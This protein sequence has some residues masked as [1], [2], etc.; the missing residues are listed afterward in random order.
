MDIELVI[1]ALLSFFLFLVLLALLFR[2]TREEA[3]ITWLIRTFFTVGVLVVVFFI[4]KWGVTEI[5]FWASLY[6]LLTTLFVFGIFSIM[7]ASLT[8]RIFTE[9]ADTREG[10]TIPELMKKYNRNLIITRRIERLV[11]SKELV[12]TGRKFMLGKMSYFRT[13][14]FL[15]KVLRFAFG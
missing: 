14:E 6:A 2:I 12:N 13:R 8:L 4:H 7:E 1:T 11:Y 3:A 5:L 9:I 15:L 10:I